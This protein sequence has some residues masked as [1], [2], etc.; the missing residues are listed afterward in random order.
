MEGGGGEER[1]GEGEM[2][3]V[4]AE[5]GEKGN[6]GEERREGDG[7]MRVAKHRQGKEVSKPAERCLRAPAVAH[8]AAHTRRTGEE[9][10]RDTC[11]EGAGMRG[12]RR[13]DATGT[14]G[15]RLI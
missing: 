11:A 12:V 14:D 8:V 3:R 6:G 4:E 5:R 2:R 9:R 7:E 15:G 13:R 1:R 10:K